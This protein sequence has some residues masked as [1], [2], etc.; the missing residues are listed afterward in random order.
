MRPIWLFMAAYG[1]LW[2][3]M[4]RYGMPMGCYGLLWVGYGLAMG[5]R[6]LTPSRHIPVAL[7]NLDS[8]PTSPT[9]PFY[10]G[11]GGV[12]CGFLPPPPVILSRLFKLPLPPPS[13]R[14]L[15][16]ICYS[17]Y[18]HSPLSSTSYSI[19][20]SLPLPL[21]HLLKLSTLPKLLL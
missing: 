11:V 10:C 12:I 6:S 15:S 5:F 21:P 18:I 13:T 2:D 17:T 20:S 19:V 8:P 4:G 1:M 14:P 7:L 3:V 9:G 16:T